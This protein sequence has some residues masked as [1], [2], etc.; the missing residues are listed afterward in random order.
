MKKVLDC[1]RQ[2][3]RFFRE[4][5]LRTFLFL[6]VLFIVAIVV[7]LFYFRLHPNAALK[8]I[9]DLAAMSGGF[10]RMTGQ[11]QFLE[12]ILILA[13][14]LMAAFFTLILGLIP[15]FLLPLLPMLRTG[16][17]LA[18]VIHWGGKISFLTLTAGI[19]PF[20]HF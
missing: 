9:D 14:N 19:L 1:Y 8:Q 11:A 3:W 17:A 20:W 13:K 7:S 6:S 2:E 18:A 16:Y 10:D 5:H 15:L 12:L 4:R